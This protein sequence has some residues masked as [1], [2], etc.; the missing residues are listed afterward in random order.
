MHKHQ[1]TFPGD[2]D[3]LLSFDVDL[4][5]KGNTV[6]NCNKNMET[7]KSVNSVDRIIYQPIL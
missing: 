5:R 4:L 7:I 6:F 2:N 3:E 1:G